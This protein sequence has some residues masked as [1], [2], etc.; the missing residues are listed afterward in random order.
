MRRSQIWSECS[1]G[2]IK[3][4]QNGSAFLFV[5]SDASKIQF[6]NHFSKGEAAS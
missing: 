4:G 2:G 3:K 1:L 6:K 5:L